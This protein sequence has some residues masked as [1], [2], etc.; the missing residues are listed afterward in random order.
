MAW[1][2]AM[3]V[4][5]GTLPLNAPL[6]TA[7]SAGIASFLIVVAS[8]ISCLTV[9]PAPFYGFASTFAYLS[10]A[11]GASSAAAM[12]TPGWKNAVVSVPVSLLVGTALGVLDGRLAQALTMRTSRLRNVITIGGTQQ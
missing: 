1:L 3:F 8:R 12:T 4:S 11:P 9:V 5:T 7:T 10:L 2:V 6:A